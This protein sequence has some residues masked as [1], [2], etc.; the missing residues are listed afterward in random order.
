H[1]S[2]CTTRPPVA[3]AFR[4]HWHAIRSEVDRNCGSALRVVVERRHFALRLRRRAETALAGRKG[5]ESWLADLLHTTNPRTDVDPER[6]DHRW[7]RRTDH[8]SPRHSD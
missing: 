3:G 2:V 4:S 7:D 5:G 8:K 6:Q 1:N